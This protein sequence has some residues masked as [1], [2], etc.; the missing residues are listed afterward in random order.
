M[1]AAYKTYEHC[2]SE[3]NESA[4]YEN[5]RYESATCGSPGYES[6]DKYESSFRTRTVQEG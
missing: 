3:S 5:K 1:R 2:E 4:S 6:C